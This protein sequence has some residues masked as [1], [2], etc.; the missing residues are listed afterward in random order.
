MGWLNVAVAVPFRSDG[1]TRDAAWD[2]CRRFWEKLGWPISVADSPDELFSRSQSRNAAVEAI[3][4]PWD[5]VVIADADLVLER[6][7]QA[8][9]AARLAHQTGQ[10]A[11]GHDRFIMLT[12]EGTQA[13]LDGQ[14]RRLHE[15]EYAIGKTWDGLFFVPHALWAEVG[16]Y[17]ERFIGHWGQG[18]AFGVACRCLGGG[19]NRVNGNMYH[20]WHTAPEREWHPHKD[21][22]RQLW[23]RYEALVDDP[24]GMRALLAER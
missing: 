9:Q 16:G 11:V 15:I 12:A 20:L 6:S 14:P 13:M 18:I 3:T 1:G 2:Y 19:A 10:M 17:D 7:D 4:E 24:A 22:N 23:Q 21:A 8:K 5:V